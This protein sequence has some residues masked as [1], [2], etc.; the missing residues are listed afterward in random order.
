MNINRTALLASVAT[1]AL[2][3]GT[4]S[5]QRKSS[6]R[7]TTLRRRRPSPILRPNHIL[8]N[9]WP[10]GA[11]PRSLSALIVPSPIQDKPRSRMAE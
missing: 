3:A 11:M 7:V 4:G 2:T 6:R 1:L 5:L 10:A 9:R 8:L